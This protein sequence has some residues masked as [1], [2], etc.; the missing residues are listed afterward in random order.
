M[1]C[2]AAVMA[3]VTV[4]IGL[5]TALVTTWACSTDM[6]PVSIAIKVILDIILVNR[7]V[8]M[9]RNLM[10]FGPRSHFFL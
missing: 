1:P 3:G 6:D 8:V 9:F 2:C 5:K 7:D 4:L 10:C